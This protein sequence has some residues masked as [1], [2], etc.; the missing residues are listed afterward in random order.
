MSCK[1]NRQMSNYQLTLNRSLQFFQ[2]FK[3]FTDNLNWLVSILTLSAFLK[4]SKYNYCEK[5][6]LGL[7]NRFELF[8][9]FIKTVLPLFFSVIDKKFLVLPAD[10]FWG[11]NESFKEFLTLSGTSLSFPVKQHTIYTAREAKERPYGQLF[12]DFIFIVLQ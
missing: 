9:V 10:V 8:L 3:P 1:A 12:F 7:F 4:L 5:Y 2:S 6:L 11:A